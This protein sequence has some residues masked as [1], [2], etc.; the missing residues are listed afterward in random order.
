MAKSNRQFEPTNDYK[1]GELA[2]LFDVARST[3]CNWAQDGKLKHYTTP[4]GDRR[5]P[6]TDVVAFMKSAGIPLSLLDN[7][8]M[9]RKPKRGS[10]KLIMGDLDALGIFLA[11]DLM[12]IEKVLNK[13]MRK[14]A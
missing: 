11:G 8:D 1:P 6:R 4:G 3:I 9:R 14:Q 12:K 2:K 13:H 10:I 5:F 7:L